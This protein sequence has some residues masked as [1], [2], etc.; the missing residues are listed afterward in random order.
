MKEIFWD[1]QYLLPHQ[2]WL[3]PP[4]YLSLQ[5]TILPK[6]N[7]TLIVNGNFLLHHSFN[8]YYLIFYKKEVSLSIY[9]PTYLPTYL[10]S[11]YPGFLGGSDGK[12]SACNVGDLGSIP[13]LGRFPGGEHGNRL[14]YSC[15]E[16][17]HG[18]RSLAG[19]SP[20]GCKELDTTEWLSTHIQLSIYLSMD[21]WISISLNGL[22]SIIYFEAQ[23][24]K[25][26]LVGYSSKW[27]LCLFSC[28]HRSLSTSLLWGTNSSLTFHFLCTSSRISYFAKRPPLPAS[29]FWLQ[30]IH[31]IQHLGTWSVP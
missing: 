6:L 30:M 2:I 22:F 8:V 25:I 13:G 29:C 9:L 7:V 12:E 23:I 14:Q 27:L 24:S 5:L 16:N 18:Q 26:W 10:L 21:T 15:L 4:A 17:S 1:C 31:R 28:P 11:I 20:W 19:Y 3:N